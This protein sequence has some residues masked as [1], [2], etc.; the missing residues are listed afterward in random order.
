MD[1]DYAQTRLEFMINDCEASVLLT[2]SSIVQQL[3]VHNTKVICVDQYL[4]EH[5]SDPT[6]IVTVRAP[7]LCTNLANVIYTSG[8]TGTPKGVMVPHRG[9]CNLTSWYG[10]LWLVMLLD[11]RANE[12]T[13]V[14]VRYKHFYEVSSDDCASQ[15]ISPGFDPIAIELWPFLTCGARIVIMP[16]DIR[17]SPDRIVE[18]LVK[19]GVTICLLPTALIEVLKDVTLPAECRL[20][21]LLT[22]GDKLNRGPRHKQPFTLVDHYGPT[23]VSVATSVSR[24]PVQEQGET[25]IG[26]PIENYKVLYWTLRL[27]LSFSLSLCVAIYQISTCQVAICVT[28]R[29]RDCVVIF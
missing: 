24:V 7:M 26:K 6:D 28:F 29:I 22:G 18:F 19:Y 11:A 16:N 12:S 25:N 5:P 14:S 21:Y 17:K 8:S 20:R 1:P 13:D 2:H 3:P 23:E 10:S 27:F 15:A 9:L 4:A